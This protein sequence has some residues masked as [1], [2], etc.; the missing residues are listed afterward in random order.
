MQT[1]CVYPRPHAVRAQVSRDLARL[2]TE[3]VSRAIPGLRVVSVSLVSAKAQEAYALLSYKAEYAL[4]VGSAYAQ[5]IQ[6]VTALI[7][8]SL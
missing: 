3:S 1:V 7:V 5:Q 8:V 6:S 2:K 4:L